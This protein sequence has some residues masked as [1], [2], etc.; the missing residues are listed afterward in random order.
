MAFN[1][2]KFQ[3]RKEKEQFEERYGENA[4]V[5]MKGKPA[6]TPDKPQHSFPELLNKR[7]TVPVYNLPKFDDGSKP[8]NNYPITEADKLRRLLRNGAKEKT[9]LDD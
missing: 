9:F 4:A 3:A 8:K 7:F 2:K 5:M 1:F 6:E